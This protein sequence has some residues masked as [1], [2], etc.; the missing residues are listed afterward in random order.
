MPAA[1]V[2]GAG[3]LAGG[4]V[5]GGGQAG[6]SVPGVVA[7]LPSGDAR[8][9]RQDRL[10][11]LQRLALRFLVHAEHD[12]VLGRV[13]VQSRDVADP[14]VQLGVG[15][16][17]ESLAA[18]GLQAEPAPHP[19]DGIVADRDLPAAAQP[20]RQPPRGPVRDPLLLQRFRWRGHGRGQDLAYRLPGQHRHRAAAARR[21][22]QPRQSRPCVLPPPLY[23]RRPGAAGPPGDLRPGQARRGQQD[24]PGPLRNPG[25]NPFDRVR[26]SS[27]ARSAS[28][29]I[30]TR[31]RLGMR[32]SPFMFPRKH[33]GRH[34]S[35]HYVPIHHAPAL[36]ML[37]GPGPP[38]IPPFSQPRRYQSS[39]TV[40]GAAICSSGLPSASMPNTISTS[41]PMIMMPPPTTYPM[42]SPVRLEPSPISTP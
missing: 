17:P 5:Q 29:T 15:G 33:K 35:D 9:Q 41:P 31:T 18:A 7:G 42:A 14:G 32:H 30:R 3:D 27:S 11:A 8:A 16:E 38:D 24:D 13:Q 4:G 21:V 22:F 2:A 25:R 39:T 23:D 40:S 12:C 1:G 19:R 26:R 28:G 34:A 20:V 36:T 10:G 6:D 37:P